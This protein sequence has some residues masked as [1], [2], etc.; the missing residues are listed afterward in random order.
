MR[1]QD[2]HEECFEA[3][4]PC[5][6]ILIYPSQT[7]DLFPQIIESGAGAGKQTDYACSTRGFSAFCAVGVASKLLP[8]ISFPFLWVAL[9]RDGASS[10]T[11]FA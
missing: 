8:A 5:A 3:A 2:D 7:V 10:P 9:P 6:D 4:L 11:S 1:K